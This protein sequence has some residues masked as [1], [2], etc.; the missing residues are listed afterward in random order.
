MFCGFSDYFTRKRKKMVIYR[1]TQKKK[2]TIFSDYY[3]V[4]YF[5]IVKCKIFGINFVFVVFKFG[6]TNKI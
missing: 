1:K 6:F 2:N 3:A 5:K 4:L